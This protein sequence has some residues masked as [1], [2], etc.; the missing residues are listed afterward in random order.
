MTTKEES[1]Q[2]TEKNNQTNS[3]NLAL[4]GGVVGAGIGLLSSPG[5]SKKVMKSLSESEVMRSAGK[6]IKR[7]A[8]EI[9][10]EQA[11][12]SFRQTATGYMN[13]GGFLPK[14]RNEQQEDQEGEQQDE[15]KE[16]E[17][18]QE[19]SS[20]EYEEIKEDN[21]QLNDRLERIEEMLNNLV[22]SKK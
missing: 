9:L 11:V 6:E 10:M 18:S 12:N 13:G 22:E 16:E 19:Q 8:Q 14:K 17:S 3:M 5:T 21:K 15:S 2:S 4:I 1:K 7:T 20:S